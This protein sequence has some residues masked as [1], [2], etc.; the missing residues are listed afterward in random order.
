MRCKVLAA[1]YE[2]S[3]ISYIYLWEDC[4]NLYISSGNHGKFQA[5]LFQF[6]FVALLDCYFRSFFTFS[7]KLGAFSYK[8]CPSSLMIKTEHSI[9]YDSLAGI[10]FFIFFILKPSRLS[11]MSILSPLTIKT[12]YSMI[13]EG[14]AGRFFI[15]FLFSPKPSRLSVIFFRIPL[16]SKQRILLFMRFDRVFFFISFFFSF[17]RN[18]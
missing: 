1:P 15:Y 4:F 2:R 3:D 18:K 8:F 11:D 16:K 9:T 13:Y 14:L 17:F 5:S 10:F 7:L 12:E 6:Y